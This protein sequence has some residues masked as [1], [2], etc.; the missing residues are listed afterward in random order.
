MDVKIISVDQFL[1]AHQ[2]IVIAT[3][4][5]GILENQILDAKLQC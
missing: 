2:V 5:I 4:A 3:H 1:Y